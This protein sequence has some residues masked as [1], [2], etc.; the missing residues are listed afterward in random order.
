M[1]NDALTKSRLTKDDIKL[2]ADDFVPRD[3]RRRV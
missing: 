2:H 3:F 1:I